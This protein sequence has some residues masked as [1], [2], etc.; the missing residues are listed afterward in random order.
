MFTN[1]KSAPLNASSGERCAIGK[2]ERQH[3]VQFALSGDSVLIYTGGA[4]R[5]A[6]V[7]AHLSHGRSFITIDEVD[8]EPGLHLLRP[9]AKIALFGSDACVASLQVALL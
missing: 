5:V 9:A 8:V 6:I 4:P 2:Y 1:S 7:D 3:L